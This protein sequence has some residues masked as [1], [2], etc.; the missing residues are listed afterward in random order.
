MMH[1]FNININRWHPKLNVD[2][3][4][5]SPKICSHDQNLIITP[6]ERGEDPEDDLFSKKVITPSG[7]VHI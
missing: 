3:L 6:M 5:L 7:V 2:P 1:Y 4:T